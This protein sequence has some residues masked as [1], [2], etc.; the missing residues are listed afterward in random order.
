MGK[1]VDIYHELALPLRVADELAAQAD[2]YYIME[3]DNAALDAASQ[4]LSS[5]PLSTPSPSYDSV[6]TTLVQLHLD[7]GEV[8]AAADVAIQHIQGAQQSS[9]MHRELT[10]SAL[11]VLAHL[12]SGRH[13]HALQ[14]AQT[15]LELAQLLEDPEC[16][17]KARLTLAQVC[18]ETE[19]GEDAREYAEGA[20]SILQRLNAPL[21][22][23][24]AVQKQ[25]AGVLL[26]SGHPAAAFGHASDARENYGEGGDTLGK[27]EA[28]L[29]MSECE[30]AQGTLDL[31]IATC[32]EV[33]GLLKAAGST[34]LQ[35]SALAQLSLLYEA[36]GDLEGALR[37]TREQRSLVSFA[38]FRKLEAQALER[39]G[40]LFFT[41]EKYDMCVQVAREGHVLARAKKNVP[42]QV[43]LLML[44]VDAALQK[45]LPTKL[46]S[47]SAYRQW[48]DHIQQDAQMAINLCQEKPCQRRADSSTFVLRAEATF[49]YAKALLLFQGPQVAED[50]AKEALQYFKQGK[51]KRGQRDVR[52][53]FLTQQ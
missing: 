4:A 33:L 6:V 7:N 30:A 50:M 17:A 47:D 29:L 18:A 51:H 11:L 19:K 13:L 48:K 3:N 25:A 40:N 45:P 52:S 1:A 8:D 34:R 42:L 36:A 49:V 35:A 27:C 28:L 43:S 14:K 9:D 41:L 16:E 2:V 15:G 46:R 53:R 5:V 22:D 24:A 20:V 44:I 26:A 39:L 12:R 32:T 23:V 38:G 37:M 10:A 21:T 31:A